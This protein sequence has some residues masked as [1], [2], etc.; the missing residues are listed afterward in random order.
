MSGIKVTPEQ[1]RSVSSQLSAGASNIE[2]QL[3][4]L[5]SAV[6]PLGSDWAGPAQARF[7]E[8]WAQWQRSAKSLNEALLGISRLTNQ[9]SQAYQST[10]DAI[11]R[12]FGTS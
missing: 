1:L 11:A 10:E 5:T 3:G 12:S 7:Q 9:A 2:G 8:L 6:S 4:Q